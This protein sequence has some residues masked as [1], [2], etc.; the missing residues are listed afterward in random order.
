MILC[1]SS[2]CIWGTR[3]KHQQQSVQHESVFINR[4]CVS[5]QLE[6]ALP[7]TTSTAWE[8]VRWFFRVSRPQLSTAQKTIRSTWSCTFLPAANVWCWCSWSRKSRPGQSAAQKSAN[9]N[10]KYIIVILQLF[11]NCFMIY[12]DFKCKCKSTVKSD[13]LAA[14]ADG[15]SCGQVSLHHKNL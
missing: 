3:G 5:K 13:E 12:Y 7:E 6:H 14:E 9:Y 11:Y 8:G 15:G 10:S 4:F 1:W 2:T